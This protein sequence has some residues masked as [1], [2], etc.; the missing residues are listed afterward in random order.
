MGIKQNSVWRN[1]KY[2]NT[3]K[4]LV[5]DDIYVEAEHCPPIENYRLP[6]LDVECWY[7]VYE[8][9]PGVTPEDILR[10]EMEDEAW[11]AV[12]KGTNE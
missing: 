2:W 8:F 5:A 10:C 12:I 3:V 9:L 6:P 7:I 4:V 11:D 1:K